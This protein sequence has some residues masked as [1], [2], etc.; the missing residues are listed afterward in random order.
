MNN[1]TST[2]M[3]ADMLKSTVG[4]SIILSIGAETIQVGNLDQNSSISSFPTLD[5][6]WPLLFQVI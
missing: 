6:K 1:F 3:D 4:P 2:S 5:Q